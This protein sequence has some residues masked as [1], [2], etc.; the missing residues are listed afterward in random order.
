MIKRTDKET[1]HSK[2]KEKEKRIFEE[3]S[4]DESNNQPDAIIQSEQ[5]TE[6]VEKGHVPQSL[7]G[8][9][10]ENQLTELQLEKQNAT[11]I[12]KRRKKAGALN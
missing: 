7:A 5:H 12:S 9:S 2:I 4:E 11:E 8:Q 3:G 6:G 1:R 10:H